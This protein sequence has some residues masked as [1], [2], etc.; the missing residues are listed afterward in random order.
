MDREQRVV[1]VQNMMH[2]AGTEAKLDGW[3]QQLEA[4]VLHPE[5]SELIFYADPLLAAQAVV[6]QVLAYQP[7][8]P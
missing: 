8:R 3:I 6:E 7:T 5:V 4:K 2:A 1:M